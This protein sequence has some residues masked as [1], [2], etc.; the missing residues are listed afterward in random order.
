MQISALNRKS[1]YQWY[2]GSAFWRERQDAC[3]RRANFTCERCKKR[4][5]TQVHH[6]TYL[7]VFNEM[8]SDLSAL[9]YQ[10]HKTI[11]WRQPANDN[12]IQLELNLFSE[13]P[14]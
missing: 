10:C 8:P 3:L 7:R 4:R 2:L 1:A 6:L 13:E 9:C 14:P 5:A 12:Q 11:H